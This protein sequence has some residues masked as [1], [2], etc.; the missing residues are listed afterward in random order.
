MPLAAPQLLIPLRISAL[1]LFFTCVDGA[2]TG[3]LAGFEAFNHLAR[4]QLIKGFST[5]PS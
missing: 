3:A 5:S 4:L 2:Q 1:A